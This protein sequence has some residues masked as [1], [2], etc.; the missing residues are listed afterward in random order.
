MIEYLSLRKISELYEP[1]LSKAVEDVV[2]SGIYLYGEQTAAFEREWADYCGARH[3]VGV[4]SGLDALTLILM[5]YKRLLGWHDGD[6]V[7]VSAH[8]FV[9]SFLAVCRAGLRPVACDVDERDFLIDASLCESLITPRTRAIMPVHIY[10]ALCNM[11]SIRDIAR[12]H[13]LKVVEDAA[14]AHGAEDAG[15]AK[16]GSLGDAAAFS[17]YPAKNIGALGDAGAVVTSD[18]ALAEMV[19]VMANYG[20]A[21][22]Y[23]HVEIGLNSRISELQAAVLRVKLRHIG[24]V[25]SHRRTIARAYNLGIRHAGISLPY[26]GRT[27][28]GGVYHVYPLMSSS[29]DGLRSY[30]LSHGVGT[31]I[32]YPVAPHNQKAMR[33][34][35]A[36]THA[37][38]A[39]KI[40]CEELSLP[41]N[42]ALTMG[43][44][45]RII[46]LINRY[47]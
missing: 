11:S 8:T 31:N 33:E 15:G 2:R 22:K 3:C 14:Q 37:P 29:R 21:S 26:G 46:N 40:S 12:R 43:E 19:R 44:T 28:S 47:E 10:G 34:I 1:E 18:A 23:H 38:V 41:I 27:L 16:A 30:L 25:I 45:E 42:S 9:A 32:H 24:D 7:I 17:F 13:G 35:L 5:A 20:S 4:A 39:E 6:E 36:G